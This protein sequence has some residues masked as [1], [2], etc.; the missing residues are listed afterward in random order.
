MNKTL[1]L[2]LDD[3]LLRSNTSSFVTNYMRALSEEVAP[4]IEVDKFIDALVFATQK[5][6]SNHLPDCTLCNPVH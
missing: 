4:L 5:M 1:L 3:T 2:D 6:V